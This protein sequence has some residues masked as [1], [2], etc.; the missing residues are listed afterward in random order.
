MQTSIKCNIC[1]KSQVMNEKSLILYLY[2]SL[3]RILYY[4]PFDIHHSVTIISSS[5]ICPHIL[6]KIPDKIE[7]MNEWITSC[8]Q[9]I[10]FEASEISSNDIYALC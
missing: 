3:S 10:V 6:Q 8:H 4:S 5:P 7:I 1:N 2:L 9:T